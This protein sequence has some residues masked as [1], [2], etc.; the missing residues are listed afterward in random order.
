MTVATSVLVIV[1]ATSLIA[2]ATI[3]RPQPTTKIRF[4]DAF[5]LIGLGA[6]VWMWA[7][8]LLW[9]APGLR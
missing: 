4:S 2:V 6:Y 5:G 9:G 8:V 3:F 7:Y 1:A